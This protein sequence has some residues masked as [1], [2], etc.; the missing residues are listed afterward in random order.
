MVHQLLGGGPS[1][2]DW[3]DAFDP[4]SAQCS[5]SDWER[6]RLERLHAVQVSLDVIAHAHNIPLR[7]LR[8][9]NLKHL[10]KTFAD[11]VHKWQHQVYALMTEPTLDHAPRVPRL[12][13]GTEAK[14]LIAVLQ[15]HSHA[16]T[17]RD[18]V[19]KLSRPDCSAHDQQLPESMPEGYAEWFLMLLPHL[20]RDI[21]LTEMSNPLPVHNLARMVEHWALFVLMWAWSRAEQIE[22][23]LR[24]QSVDHPEVLAAA[25]DVEHLGLIVLPA[26]QRR[27]RVRQE[28]STALLVGP[29]VRPQS[30]YSD[31]GGGWF[32]EPFNRFMRR[33]A[34]VQRVSG[35]DGVHEKAPDRSELG[36]ALQ[37]RAGIEDDEAQRRASQS[38]RALLT[39]LDVRLAPDLF[40]W[41]NGQPDRPLSRA[42]WESMAVMA[43]WRARWG[44]L[45]QELTA[46]D[47]RPL[48]VELPRHRVKMFIPG[49]RSSTATGPAAL[50]PL[51]F[52]SLA[53]DILDGN[54]AA[55]SLEVNAAINMARQTSEA[56]WV[57]APG[58]LHAKVRERQQAGWYAYISA[59]NHLLAR[60]N[61]S[62]RPEGPDA[63]GWDSGAD[64]PCEE[65]DHLLRGFGGRICRYLIGMARA[66]LAEIYWL[67]YSSDPPSLRHV[68]SAERLVQH[69]ADRQKIWKESGEALVRSLM[70]GEPGGQVTDGGFLTVRATFGGQIVP[71][72]HERSAAFA[73]AQAGKP[74]ARFEFYDRGVVPQD[75]IAVPL[76]F[77]GRVVGVLGLAGVASSR[78]FDTRLYP[79]LRILAQDLGLAMYFH[80]QV[81]Q[82][83][84][85]NWLASNVQLELWQ[86]HDLRNPENPMTAVAQCLADIFLCPGVHIWLRD[87]RSIDE[88]YLLGG[89]TALDA[90][91]VD[92][93][94]PEHA[95]S[96]TLPKVQ[97]GEGAPLTRPTFAFALDPWLPLSGAGANDAAVQ[98]LRG[99]F[100]QARIDKGSQTSPYDY[101]TAA[102]GDLMLGA[103]FLA[104]LDDSQAAAS[105]IGALPHLR[106]D[107]YK[108]R[109]WT[110]LMAF[111]LV[112]ESGGQV[113]PIGVV[114]LH[115]PSQK[116]ADSHSPWPPGWRPVVSHVQT[117]LPYVLAQT[118]TIEKPLNHLVQ[119][120]LHQGRNELNATAIKAAN[121]K[122]QLQQLLAID[123]PLGRVR[124]W[125][126]KRLGSPS[127]NEDVDL[128]RQLF[129]LD[130]LL[131]ET[132]AGLDAQ[133]SVE[134]AESLTTLSRLIERRRSIAALGH[135]LAA[136]GDVHRARW[137]DLHATISNALAEYRGD[138]RSQRI[139]LS[140]D[141]V[142]PNYRL[143]SQPRLWAWLL[144]DLAHN[145]A[146]YALVNSGVEVALHEVTLAD[147]R[148]GGY[149]IRFINEAEYDPSLD[150]P[151]RLMRFGVQG[152]AGLSR[153]QRALSRSKLSRIG[154]G[155]GL[156]G[157]N[158]LASTL[159][160]K[161]SIEIKPQE[162]RQGCA[163]YYF[164]LL[165]PSDLL[166]RETVQHNSP[167]RTK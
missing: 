54:L 24:R 160:M 145:I 20:E 14:E 83:R 161:F 166:R 110:D 77:N 45:L 60:H 86:E 99:K 129:Q 22:Q 127:A 84:R 113:R 13:S 137:L 103:E 134:H 43:S 66:D 25:L 5:K 91:E 46:N 17:L 95:P 38:R 65:V 28:L 97:D 27:G 68:G 163:R 156:W 33:I 93:Q 87:P 31:D 9:D 62:D 124:P 100:I 26:Y 85:I 80:N 136:A 144:S 44:S 75:G 21:W 16:A 146:K 29:F 7:L 67:D 151:A 130:Q 102:R 50:E 41:P 105:G 149:K 167:D 34:R 147:G 135:D 142:P 141:K 23:I 108:K 94:L 78:H 18:W 39:L 11:F 15:E 57:E 153:Q 158:E 111:A 4:D 148:R 101:E 90:F 59:I 115:G 82:M 51:V 96:V 106:D 36:D 164:D 89:S 88:R 8:M 3:F 133:G 10:D 121:T 98:A 159:G 114:S 118:E 120:L 63:P 19:L 6:R 76:T 128:Q 42:N 74:R 37:S 58:N 132:A 122:R 116:Q 125:L 35:W 47:G 70:S 117:Y 81:W 56:K 154:T 72:P 48:W 40:R 61:R 155:I 109:K 123:E 55:A 138:L 126:R 73:Q 112:L 119:Y 152:S 49:T 157:V 71:L 64:A 1:V 79:S 150:A 30:A 32:W 53:R 52:T 107:L 92:G 143:L 140:T 104:S 2:R 12:L 69:R 131:V 139:Y 162:K 165:I